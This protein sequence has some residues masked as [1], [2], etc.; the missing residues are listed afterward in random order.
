[1]N[2]DARASVSRGIADDQVE[3][4]TEGDLQDHQDAQLVELAAPD[5]VDERDD[6]RDATA[7]HQ[8]P[9]DG[10]SHPGQNVIGDQRNDDVEQ[11]RH[12]PHETARSSHLNASTSHGQYS[13]IRQKPSA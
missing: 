1:M 11:I 6:R 10:Q 5:R 2:S 4:E 13:P 7:D 9:E 3:R 12:D 8:R